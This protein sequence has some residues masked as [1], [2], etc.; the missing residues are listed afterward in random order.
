MAF[1]IVFFNMDHTIILGD[2]PTWDFQKN[3]LY[4]QRLNEGTSYAGLQLQEEF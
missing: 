4:T 1:L 2:I 3:T